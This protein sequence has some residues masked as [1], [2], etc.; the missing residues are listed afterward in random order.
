MPRLALARCGVP[1]GGVPP[2]LEDHDAGP[3]GAGGES[4]GGLRLEHAPRHEAPPDLRPPDVLH[5]RAVPPSAHQPAA[6]FGAGCLSRGAEAPDGSPI[7]AVHA[8][9]RLP[10]LGNGGD[11]A[12]ACHPG[13]RHEFP[14]RSALRPPAVHRQGGAVEERGVYEPGPHHPPEIGRPGHDIPRPDVVLSIGIAAAPERSDMIPRDGLGRT[15][16]AGREENICGGGGGGVVGPKRVDIQAGCIRRSL[17]QREE[18]APCDILGPEGGGRGS[19]PGGKGR[20]HHDR[21]DP[22]PRSRGRHPLVEGEE[23]PAPP[24]DEVLGEDYLGPRNIQ[25]HLDLLLGE[26]VGY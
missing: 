14:E 8:P 13:S 20:R 25:S 9:R 19:A 24:R 18:G 15:G 23:F 17:S 11:E 21:F 12:E 7:E 5:H 4:G 16:G 2:P 3:E 22:R 6:A 1:V 26:A 10:G